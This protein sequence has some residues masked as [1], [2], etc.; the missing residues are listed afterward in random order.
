MGN[1]KSIS[2]GIPNTD[3]ESGVN[4]QEYWL[5]LDLGFST[6][7]IQRSCPMQC[8]RRNI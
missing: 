5:E 8:G 4:A 6:K 3:G 1:G 2:F 7:V